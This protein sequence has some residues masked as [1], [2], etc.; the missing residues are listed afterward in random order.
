MGT[1]LGLAF[2]EMNPPFSKGNNRPGPPPVICTTQSVSPWILGS[3]NRFVFTSFWIPWPPMLWVLEVQSASSYIDNPRAPF[4]P[5]VTK[6]N[7]VMT[8]DSSLDLDLGTKHILDVFLSGAEVVS[9][10]FFL[11][12]TPI[13]LRSHTVLGD[14]KGEKMISIKS[15]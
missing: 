13:F 9:C 4:I 7:F 11:V 2:V 1:N 15:S 3:R 10:S 14:K 6:P 8:S 12:V 5:L